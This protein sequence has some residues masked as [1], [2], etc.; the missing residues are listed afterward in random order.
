MLFNYV[1]RYSNTIRFLQ[2]LV[3][4]EIIYMPEYTNILHGKN[5]QAGRLS[6]FIAVKI[7]TQGA[8]TS[9]GLTASPWQSIDMKLYITYFGS[10]NKIKVNQGF[11]AVILACFPITDMIQTPAV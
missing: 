10:S 11:E 2:Q 3:E 7:H 6:Y 4:G 8:M 1:F 9:R 5:H